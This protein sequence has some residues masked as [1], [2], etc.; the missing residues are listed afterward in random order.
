MNTNLINLIYS[1]TA[2]PTPIP[3]VAQTAPARTPEQQALYNYGNHA[4]LAVLSFENSHTDMAQVLQNWIKHRTD[5]NA[6][7]GVSLIARDMLT[8]GASLK[9]L[10]NVPVAAQAVNNALAAGFSNASAQ[11]SSILTQ[12]ASDSG[13]ATAMQTYNSAA[14]A[15]TKSYLTIVDFFTLREITFGASDPGSVFSIPQ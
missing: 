5:P 1:L 11:L 3:A 13:L 7:A 4:G 15:Y 8:A 6:Q 2:A 12:S 14:D 9:N 10:P